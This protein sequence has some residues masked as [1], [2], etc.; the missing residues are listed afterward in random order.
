MAKYTFEQLKEALPEEIF[1]HYYSD[2]LSTLYA[3]TVFPLLD[4]NQIEALKGMLQDVYTLE[5]TPEDFLDR[6][7][8]LVPDEKKFNTI[9]LNILSKDFLSVADYVDADI[10]GLIAALGAD[11][12]IYRWKVPAR[13]VIAQVLRS[14]GITI[15]DEHLFTRLLRILESRVLNART[16]EQTLGL[17]TGPTKTSG[18]GLEE[19]RARSLLLLLNEEV[20]QLQ[21]AGVSILSDEEYYREDEEED[22]AEAAEE[23]VAAPPSEEVLAVEGGAME[24]GPVPA[25][26]G[27]VP[28]AGEEPIM[29]KSAAEIAREVAEIVA[30]PI[31]ESETAAPAPE[32]METVQPEDIQDVRLAAS[33]LDENVDAGKVQTEADLLTGLVEEAI[34]VTG[35]KFDNEDLHRRFLNIVNLYF[36]D[37]RD[38]LET[39]SKM[40]MPAA[41]GGMGMSDEDGE[42]V[43]ATLEIKAKEYHGLM[44]D[45]AAKDKQQYLAARTE[46]V[47]Q[48]A[49]IQSQKDQEALNQTYSRVVKTAGPLGPAAPAAEPSIPAA[50]PIPSKPKFIPVVGVVP[51]PSIGQTGETTAAAAPAVA[52]EP[53][54]IAAKAPPPVRLPGAFAEPAPQPAPPPPPAAPPLPRQ[55]VPPVAPPPAAPLPPTPTP[56]AL[57]SSATKADI[58]SRVAE[59]LKRAAAPPPP[60]PP[61]APPPPPP[62]LQPRS[63]MA[64]VKYVPKLTGPVDELRALTLKDFRRLSK[65]PHEA[66]LKIRDKIDLLEE[67]S[68]EVKTSGIKAW[69]DSEANRLYLE[70]LRRSLEGKPILDVIVEKEAKQEPVLTK[71]EFDAIMDLNRK[72]RFG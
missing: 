36:R 43:M 39:K 57:P 62:P 5:L 38:A 70:M 46:Q 30:E 37:L 18:T 17:L 26:T 1:D 19:S 67:Q 66:T 47:M 14:S 28:P 21:K 2:E 7:E 22:E 65:D 52:P 6:L 27:E 68:F 45:R 32:T 49:E 56:P 29:A 44:T 23:A 41:S 69:Q 10:L 4:D 9:A 15:E 8:E 3:D 11:P 42:R 58:S 60:P 34:A 12:N 55:T 35:V 63:V 71:N 31:G 40:T 33:R 54:V 50:L 64:D 20:T 13:D 53:A 24:L 72:L 59:V 61:A 25:G 48:R 16:E 51:K